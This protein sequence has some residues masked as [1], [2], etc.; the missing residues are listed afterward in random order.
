M[1]RIVLAR[2]AGLSLCASLVFGGLAALEQSSEA[3]VTV[4]CWREYCI[5]DPETGKEKCAKEEIACPPIEQ[6]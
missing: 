5:K 6:T 1:V 4:K 3:Q 2:L